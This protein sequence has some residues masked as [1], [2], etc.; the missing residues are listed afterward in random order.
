MFVSV[1]F[2]VLHKGIPEPWLDYEL[3]EMFYHGYHRPLIHFEDSRRLCQTL[4]DVDARVWDY[5][6]WFGIKYTDI[7]L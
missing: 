2:E 1:S 7:R 6:S 4:G 5:Y 3:L